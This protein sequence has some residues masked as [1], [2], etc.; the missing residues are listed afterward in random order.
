MRSP[1]PL[2]W[3]FWSGE[4]AGDTSTSNWDMGWEKMKPSKWQT[5]TGSILRAGL[6]QLSH[7][8]PQGRRNRGAKKWHSWGGSFQAAR[9]CGKTASGEVQVC[10]GFLGTVGAALSHDQLVRTWLASLLLSVAEFWNYQSTW[11]SC[12]QL[13]FFRKK[14]VSNHLVDSLWTCFDTVGQT[15][16]SCIY[17]FVLPHF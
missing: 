16:R 1:C 7:P 10:L 4:E 17:T 14:E 9:R 6:G 11:L 2:A 5:V 8:Y 13:S 15:E 3:G 12:C